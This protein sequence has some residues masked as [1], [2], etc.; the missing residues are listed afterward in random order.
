MHFG[1]I[2]QYFCYLFH[3]FIK[4]CLSV[5]LLTFL[6]IFFCIRNTFYF[7]YNFQFTIYCLVVL[8]LSLSYFLF[9]FSIFFAYSIHFTL[10]ISLLIVYVLCSIIHK[11]TKSIICRK[12]IST[13][14]I[15][16]LHLSFSISKTYFTYMCE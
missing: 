11:I 9:F 13:H 10:N 3:L 6:G 14:I 5:N 8:L 1:S 4:F 16:F 12:D 2:W 7:T 15:E